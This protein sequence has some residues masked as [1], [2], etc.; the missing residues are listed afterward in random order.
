M[1]PCLFVASNRKVL[2]VFWESVVLLVVSL[3]ATQAIAQITGT[4]DRATGSA[5]TMLKQ[6]SG[7]PAADFFVALNGSDS[8]SGTLPAPNSKQTDGPFASIARAQIAVRNLIHTHPN[9]PIIAMIRQGNYSLPLSP[10]NPGTLSFTTSDSGT[11]QTPVIWENY[12]GE[13]PMVSGGEPISALG[14]T[15]TNP[16]GNLWQVRLPANTQS[17]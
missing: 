3:F 11:S 4:A 6:S 9:R 12:P 10:T 8:W 15:W 1:S 2:I 14:L 17:F 13:V 5:R 16:A 7:S